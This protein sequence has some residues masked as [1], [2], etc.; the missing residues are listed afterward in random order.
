MNQ[1]AVAFMNWYG[2]LLILPATGILAW[3]LVT[4][5]LRK[6]R[7]SPDLKA[8]A[9]LMLL[10]I[11]GLTEMNVDSSISRLSWPL[12]IVQLIVLVLLYKSLWPLW[13]QRLRD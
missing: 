2:L 12:R 8:V 11:I 3:K 1:E 4:E 13:K 6:K 5:K 9:W 10:V 7:I